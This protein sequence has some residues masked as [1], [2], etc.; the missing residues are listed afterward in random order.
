LLLHAFRNLIFNAIKYSPLG[1]PIEVVGRKEPDWLASGCEGVIVRMRNGTLLVFLIAV[2]VCGPHL[3]QAQRVTAPTD[4]QLDEI[5][6][7]AKRRFDLV[8]DEKVKEE[9][10]EALHS[11]PFFYD[12]HVTVTTK[13]GVVTLEGMVFDDWD[14]RQAMRISKRVAGVK[15]VVNDLEIK[16]GGE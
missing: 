10:E 16:L 1:S 13:N 4:T 2:L 15:R 11:D 8:A 3:A 9:V 14:L 7:T 12:A 5:V 6:V